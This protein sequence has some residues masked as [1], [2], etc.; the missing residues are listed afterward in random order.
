MNYPE[1]TDTIEIFNE[2]TIKEK[3]SVFIGQVFQ[4]DSEAQFRN[5]L[6]EVKKNITM[7]HIIVTHSDYWIIM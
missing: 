6:A 1:Q 7:L 2:F 5:T 4:T 3:G